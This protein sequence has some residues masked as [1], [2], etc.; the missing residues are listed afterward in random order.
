MRPKSQNYVPISVKGAIL[1]ALV[2]LL[3]LA[4]KDSLLALVAGLAPLAFAGGGQSSVEEADEDE[5]DVVVERLHEVQVRAWR[6]LAAAAHIIDLDHPDRGVWARADVPMPLVRRW[7]QPWPGRPPAVVRGPARAAALVRRPG[8]TSAGL[9]ASEELTTRDADEV[10]AGLREHRRRLVILGAEDTGKTNALLALFLQAQHTRDTQLT[11]EQRRDFPLP[12][13]VS[14]AGWPED[15]QESAAT[16]LLGWIVNR[17]EEDYPGLLAHGASLEQLLTRIWESDGLRGDRLMLFIDGIDTLPEDRRIPLLKKLFLQS[18]GRSLALACR[19]DTWQ[20]LAETDREGWAELVLAAPGDADVER[21][22]NQ[23]GRADGPEFARRLIAAGDATEWLR[24]NPR[25]LHVLHEAYR[26]RLPEWLPDQP[27]PA[28]PAPT[29]PTLTAHDVQDHLWGDLLAR[30]TWPNDVPTERAR[31]TL[32]WIAREGLFTSTRFA[33]WHVPQAARLDQTLAAAYRSVQWRRAGSALAWALGTFAAGVLVLTWL[34]LDGTVQGYDRASSGLQA[35][36]GLT[37]TD[38]SQWPWQLSL[39]RP[40]SWKPDLADWLDT[41]VTNP[42]YL[43]LGITALVAVVTVLLARFGGE[44][45]HEDGGQPQTIRLGLP[46]WRDLRSLPPVV[47]RRAA[48]LVLATVVVALVLQTAGVGLAGQLWAGSVFAALFVLVLAWLHWCADATDDLTPSGTFSSDRM[49]SRAVAVSLGTATTLVSVALSWW[50]TAAGHVPTLAQCLW[51]VASASTAVGLARGFCLGAGMGAPLLL[52]VRPGF[53]IGYAARLRLLEQA[54]ARRPLPCS[55]SAAIEILDLERTSSGRERG[56]PDALDPAMLLRQVGPLFRLR[57]SNLETYLVET[58]QVETAT[59]SAPGSAPAGG[60]PG[61][62]RATAGWV[63]GLVALSCAATVAVLTCTG[64]AAVILPR[65]PCAQ[66]NGLTASGLL[67][68]RPGS[69]L[70]LENG[71]CVGFAVLGD[72]GKSGTGK[73]GSGVGPGAFTARGVNRPEVDGTPE[74]DRAQI[75]AQIAKQ[76]AA[77]PDIDRVVTVL[78]LAPLTR[79]SGTNAINALW[80]LDGARSAQ[81]AVNADRQV[82]VRLVVANSGEN[83]TSGPSVVQ[84]INRAFPSDPRNTWSIKSVIGVAQS[85]TS[86]REALSQFSNV[87]MVAASVNGDDMRHGLVRDLEP[88]FGASFISVSPG[89]S[90]VAAAMLDPAVLARARGL[91]PNPQATAQLRIIEDPDDTYFSNDLSNNLASL[92]GPGG[93]A[94]LGP[95]VAPP[96][97]ADELR[98]TATQ[99]TYESLADSVC[100]TANAQV[101]WLFAGRGNQLTRLDQQLTRSSYRHCQPVVIAGPGGISAVAASDTAGSRLDHMQ[102]LLFYS[103]AAQPPSSSPDPKGVGWAD[104]VARASDRS[105]GY[106][107]LVEAVQRI[108]P[109]G[110]RGCPAPDPEVAQLGLSIPAGASGNGHNTL[111]PSTSGCGVRSGSAIYLCPFRAAPGTTCS[112]VTASGSSSPATPKKPRPVTAGATRGSN[113]PGRLTWYDQPKLVVK[114][115]STLRPDGLAW[116]AR[117]QVLCA[118]V[119]E[120]ARDGWVRV[121]VRGRGTGYVHWKVRYRDQN[122]YL[123]FTVPD[124]SFNP[125]TMRISSYLPK[126]GA[127]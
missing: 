89:D 95:S 73:G 1:S 94:R 88:D 57:E 90:Q 127:G 54:L 55:P 15:E 32:Q 28:Q 39:T 51:I 27:P 63:A 69:T 108:P 70:W 59:T 25:L 43:A 36:S 84:A 91:L 30:V 10:I 124:K 62:I 33:W 44:F 107:A 60:Q 118:A 75:L 109:L 56:R 12:L 26:D 52:R 11:R 114:G 80:Q 46:R 102:N 115:R 42:V 106:A 31:G 16:S 125:R 7:P 40:S 112:A 3:L 29:Q 74:R 126:C 58:A 71:Q 13:R 101:I 6:P 34:L 83:F 47:H 49:S 99:K 38:I 105:T 14:V 77:I 96:T 86:A 53:G 82:Y 19:W 50:F 121:Y 18:R 5:L 97:A 4:G 103:L 85:R 123:S 17:L 68:G 41:V 110:S 21:F 116:D 72:Q 61:R 87:Q 66:W 48:L 22:L 81:R 119:G 98:E 37:R 78:F 100:S 8:T 111:G 64:M 76:N 104:A 35:A 2:I 113:D 9:P 93:S 23:G 120:T 45:E 67:S 24:Q 92:A 65:L 20:Q 122:Y 117:M 79:T